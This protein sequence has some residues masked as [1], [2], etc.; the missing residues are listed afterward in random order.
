M[1]TAWWEKVTQ[2]ASVD[3]QRQG[4]NE[5]WAERTLPQGLLAAVSVEMRLWQTD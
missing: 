4:L 3:V 5:L 2:R 1:S